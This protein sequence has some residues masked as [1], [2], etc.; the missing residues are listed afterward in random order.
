MRGVFNRSSFGTFC[1]KHIQ[2]NLIVAC[3]L[4]V[5]CRN[6]SNLCGGS[7]SSSSAFVYPG[8]RD[9]HTAEADYEACVWIHSI[10][11]HLVQNLSGKKM[12][13]QALHRRIL[14]EI[15]QR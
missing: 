6:G 10:I 1:I 8:T 5:W 15:S 14:Y 13:R 4:W 7:S 9:F 12:R 3:C 2:K 11:C